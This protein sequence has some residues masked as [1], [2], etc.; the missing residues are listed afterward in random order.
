MCWAANRQMCWAANRQMWW[1]ANRQMWW[2]ANRQMWWAANCQICRAAN[3]QTS[4]AEP[5]CACNYSFSDTLMQT[6]QLPQVYMCTVYCDASCLLSITRHFILIH[7]HYS[8][9]LAHCLLK[10]PNPWPTDN[11]L[12]HTLFKPPNPW[13]TDNCLSHTLFTI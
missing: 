7:Y 8:S 5:L 3:H 13:P 11:C 2:A 4:W 12:S 10:P 1:A 9:K 6:L